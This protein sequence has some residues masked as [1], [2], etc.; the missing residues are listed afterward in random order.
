MKNAPGVGIH[1]KD[2]VTPCVEQDGIGGFRTNALNGEELL[3]QH[4][5]GS[6]EHYGE[7]TAMLFSKKRNECLELAGL[8]PEVAGGADEAGEFR[9]GNIRHGGGRKEFR[10]AEIGDGAGGVHPS[11][12]LD[13]D[14][15]G[16]DFEGRLPGPPVLPAM[17][18]KKGI[19]ESGEWPSFAAESAA[20][21]GRRVARLR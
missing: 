21:A 10:L 13:E 3:P 14:G 2:G 15:A 6:A 12:V 8:L 9:R 11:G 17:S 18:A 20:S 19:K 5:G 16:D 1:N 7:R 4:G